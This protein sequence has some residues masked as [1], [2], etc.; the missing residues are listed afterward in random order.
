MFNSLLM[1]SLIMYAVCVPIAIF[2]GYQLATWDDLM[3]FSSVVVVLALLMVPL[4]LKWHHFWLI[5]VWNTT[6]LVFFLPGRPSFA[7]AL[8]VASLVISVVQHAIN[9]EPMFIPVPTITW[10]LLFLAGVVL[11]TAKFTGGI[12]LGI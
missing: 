11:V 8:T 6:A 5:A 9:Q 4:L 12:G 3:S 7:L 1:R 2:V 10:P